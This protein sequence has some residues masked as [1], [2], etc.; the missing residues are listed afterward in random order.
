MLPMVLV[1]VVVVVLVPVLVLVPS[2]LVVLVPSILVVLVVV[3]IVVLAVL[4]VNLVCKAVYL[5]LGGGRPNV[6]VG[7]MCNRCSVRRD[8]EENS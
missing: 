7:G 1:V 8:G 3:L 2:V 4:A 5:V 6:L